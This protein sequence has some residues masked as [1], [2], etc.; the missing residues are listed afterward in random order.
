MS[1][2]TIFHFARL[3]FLALVL[4]YLLLLLATLFADRL[5]F[6]APAGSYVRGSELIALRTADD[7]EI[8]ALHLPNPS[9][10]YTLLYSHGNGEDL[11]TIR[12][13]LRHL[14]KAGFAV[15]AYDYRGY[16]LSEGVPSAEGTYLDIAAAYGY[17]RDELAVEPERII[18]HG[19]SV[20]GGPAV[21][22]AARVPVAG[23]ILESSFTTAFR[24]VTRLPLLPGDRFRNIDK[25]GDVE[26]PVL[27][28]HGRND[29]IVPFS[30]GPALYRAAP[31]P[32]RKYWV[33]GAGHNGLWL[34]AGPEY[35]EVLREF[36][37]LV[38]AS[39]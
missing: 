36:A 28:I 24:V 10:E 1:W 13:K 2:T 23:L 19:R 31:E 3:A 29:R 35:D 22:L 20:G 30:N 17:L 8:A 7:L 33:E 37:A 6:P 27:V 18:L 4:V 25:I 5:I 12:P 11:G 32:K 38:S 26:C 9:A 15:F 39:R 34:D 14:R 21:D 16:G